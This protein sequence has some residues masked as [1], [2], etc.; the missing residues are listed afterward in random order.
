MKCNAECASPNTPAPVVGAVIVCAGKSE[1]SGL[2]Y[3]KVLYRIGCKTALETVLDVFARTPVSKTAVVSSAADEDNIRDL[4]S[5]YRNVTVV[6]GGSTRAESV[7]NGL[8][9]CPCDIVVIH[10]GARPFV[11]PEILINSIISAEKY[12]SGIA[13]VKSIDTPKRV[14]RNGVMTA[15]P[16]DGLYNAQTPQTFRYSEIMSAYSSVDYGA[17]TDDAE[18]YELGGFTPRLVE[19][20]YDNTKITTA[21]DLIKAVPRSCRIGVGF[22]V[23][24]LVPGR[25]LVLGGIE[26][27]FEKGL[28]GHSDADVLVHAIMDA[29]LSAASLP[30]IGVLF[31]DTDE[32]YLD[33]RSTELLKNV[34]GRITEKWQIDSVSAVVC[35]E[36]PKLAHVIPKMRD[37]LAEI[38]NVARDRINISATTTEKLG[39]IGSGDGIASDAVCLLSEKS[40]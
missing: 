21:A 3:N 22:D 29:L 24:R 4:V 35:A 18:V 31:P 12:G 26:I 8:K 15:I 6:T 13:A 19:G 32:R 23:H 9:A 36:R 17:C 14:N 20:A 34:L 16:R 5:P 30:D 27:P 25:K 38:M 7:L 11:S 28:L 37:N 1:R 40:I 2:A 33:V 10:D 39:I